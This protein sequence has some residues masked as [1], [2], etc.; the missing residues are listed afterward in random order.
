[1]T[2]TDYP[3]PFAILRAILS[4]AFLYYGL[5]KIVGAEVAVTMYDTLGYGQGPRFM[6]GTAET[7]GAIGLWLRGRQVFAALLLLATMCIGLA[8]LLIYL[9]PPYFPVPHLLIGSAIVAYAYRHQI[10]PAA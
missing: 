4:T 9:G 1:M 5:Q 6:T 3:I 8:A 10:R 7:L 2:A